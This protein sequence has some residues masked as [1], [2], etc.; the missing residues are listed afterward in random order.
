MGY[1]DLHVHTTCSDGS[2][3]PAQVIRK[4]CEK[5]L[6]AVAI[7]DHD[8]VAGLPA[9]QKEARTYPVKVIP[10]VEISSSLGSRSI[11]LLG[12]G[13]DCENP[14]FLR[15]L[16]ILT[17]FRDERNLKMCAQMRSYGMEIDY[18]DFRRQLGCRTVTRSHFAAFMIEH[19]FASSKAEAYQKYLGKGRPCYVP[20]RTLP[21]LDAVKLILRAGGIPVVAH[22]VQYRLSDRG[23][24]QLFTLLKD[25]GIQGI[26]AIYPDNTHE[27]EMKFRRFAE[28]L[29]L[30]I[31]GGTD[32]HG[33]FTPGVDIGTGRGNLMIPQS[34]LQNIRQ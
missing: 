4:A 33:D 26:E 16:R 21:S 8:T 17:H 22:P 23:Y 34:I 31:T 27:Q 14:A 6:Y 10:G 24:L 28:D 19:G 13:I 30:F 18:E 25:F 1:I 7:T 3:T 20:M 9:A 2:L 11:H 32:F 12:Y 5:G 15:A 29:N